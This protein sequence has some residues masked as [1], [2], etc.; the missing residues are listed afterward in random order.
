MKERSC[1]SAVLNYPYYYFIYIFGCYSCY[2]CFNGFKLHFFVEKEN[3]LDMQEE[4]L[5]SVLIWF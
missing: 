4:I 1:S 2:Y 5:R 3:I